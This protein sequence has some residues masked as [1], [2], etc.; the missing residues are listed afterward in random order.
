MTNHTSLIQKIKTR[1]VEMGASDI[2]LTSGSHP[3]CR[4]NGDTLFFEDEEVLKL[5][6]LEHY[7]MEI[8]SEEEK[9]LFTQN[10]ELDLSLV[11]PGDTRYRVNVTRH[12]KGLSISFRVIPKHIPEFE[13]LNLPEQMK[14]IVD[15]KSGLVLV[16]GSMGSG[17]TTT[18][19]AI[20]DH[21]NRDHQKR[22]V[23]IEDPIEFVH[24]NE[25]SLI[26]HR[27]VRIH[28]KS[29]ARA[30]KSALRQGA[31]VILVGELRDLESIALA[32]TAAETGT[33]VLSTIHT[34]GAANTIN[35]LIDVFPYDQQ[36]QIQNQIAQ[37]LRAVV[38]QTLLPRVDQEGRIPAFEI[39]FQNYA[40]ANLIREGKAFQ[41]TNLIETHRDEGMISMNQTISHLLSKGII[42]ET[43]AGRAKPMELM[44]V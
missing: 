22:I 43:I 28:T 18:L 23:T 16:A 7:L 11:S 38:W 42:D 35:R 9:T 44:D 21:I 24:E 17:K 19:A 39:L 13:A 40:V 34:N 3:S 33:L 20:L 4:V 26:E 2:F 15:F 5:S 12:A 10:L 8:M 14:K 6:D 27:E 41:L 32:I 1:A 31:D 30:L 25:K 37:S 29:F 36:K